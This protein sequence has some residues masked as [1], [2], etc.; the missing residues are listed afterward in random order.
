MQVAVAQKA[1]ARV[2]WCQ[3]LDAIHCSS[4][5][6]LYAWALASEAHGFEKRRLVHRWE[7]RALLASY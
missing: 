4:M 1:F 5:W 3:A 2:K 6:V 7:L